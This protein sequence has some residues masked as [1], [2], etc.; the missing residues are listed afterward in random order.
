[1]FIFVHSSANRLLL[2]KIEFVFGM[3]SAMAASSCHLLNHVKKS[4]YDQTYFLSRYF[5]N[6]LIVGISLDGNEM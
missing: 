1:M 6:T 3:R 2:K 5:S 4:K